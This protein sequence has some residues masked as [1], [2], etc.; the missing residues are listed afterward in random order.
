M[1][2]CKGHDHPNAHC[3]MVHF[4]PMASPSQYVTRGMPADL[5]P[6]LNRTA[7]FNELNQKISEL[8]QATTSSSAMS[9]T[10]ATRHPKQKD[11]H[12]WANWTEYVQD[13][14]LSMKA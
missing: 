3:E 9:L 1:N 11:R 14:D 5:E 10:Y 2:R 13:D 6:S 4:H 7:W 8:S 12:C